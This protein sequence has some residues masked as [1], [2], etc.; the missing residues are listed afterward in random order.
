MATEHQAAGKEWSR[1]MWGDVRKWKSN[2]KTVCI[3]MI[4]SLLKKE[5]L[6]Y[7]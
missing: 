3:V 4:P 6:E 5:N 7:T 2:L 1:S